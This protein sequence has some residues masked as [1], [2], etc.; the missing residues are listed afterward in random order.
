MLMEPASSDLID[1]MAS[2]GRQVRTALEQNADLLRK[3][4]NE[5]DQR[6]RDTG[7]DYMAATLEVAKKYEEELER[8]M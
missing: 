3:V 1:T 8:L 5:I 4:G 7:E 2:D 6:I